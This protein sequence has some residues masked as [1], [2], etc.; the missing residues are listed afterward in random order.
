LQC[1][2]KGKLFGRRAA[3]DIRLVGQSSFSGF[4]NNSFDLLE[5]LLLEKIIGFMSRM[6]QECSTNCRCDKKI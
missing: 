1:D 5:N 6:S 4:A 3:V 2:A